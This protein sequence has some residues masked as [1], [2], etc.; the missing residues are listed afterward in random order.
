[1]LSVSEGTTLSLHHLYVEDEEIQP[2]PLPLPFIQSW[3][4]FLTAAVQL[5]SLQL[6]GV[7]YAHHGFRCGVF[8]PLPDTLHHLDF[9]IILD[10]T[11]LVAL[12]IIQHASH[13]VCQINLILT[14]WPGAWS[15]LDALVSIGEKFPVLEQLEQ[16]HIYTPY[17]SSPLDPDVDWTTVLLNWLPQSIPQSVAK[18]II[19]DESGLSTCTMFLEWLDQVPHPI[20]GVVNALPGAPHCHPSP[21]FPEFTPSGSK[22]P[23]HP[24]YG[25]SSCLHIL[26]DGDPLLDISPVQHLENTCIL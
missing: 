18:I 12:D 2:G 15:A 10:S 7:N 9:S 1:M 23:D 24:H 20:H 4:N 6:V 22:S 3:N 13:A 25:P 21:L 19:I 16:L 17:F 5:C 26:A 11:L 14:E 8:P